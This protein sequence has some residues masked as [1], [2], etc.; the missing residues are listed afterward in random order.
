LANFPVIQTRLSC[1]F[2]P[3]ADFY[4]LRWSGAWSQA[5]NQ[6]Q[7]FPKQV[8]GHGDFGQLE[9]DIASVPHHLCANFGQLLA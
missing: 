1:D 4:S 8:P 5:I 2:H 7:D 6:A 9:R 3:A